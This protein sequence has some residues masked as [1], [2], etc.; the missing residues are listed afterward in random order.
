MSREKTLMLQLKRQAKLPLCCPFV[1]TI[2]FVF[3]GEPT[4]T[5]LNK[6]VQLTENFMI[7]LFHYD[8]RVNEWGEFEWSKSAIHVS[9]L[10]QTKW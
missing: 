8:G 9:V 3:W 1:G 4:L 6:F 10:K 7:L 5:L 2:F